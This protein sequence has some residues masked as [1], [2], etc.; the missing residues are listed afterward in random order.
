MDRS[1]EEAIRYISGEL[2]DNPNA[3]KS[4]LIDQAAQRFD[5]DPMQTEFLINKF[6][7]NT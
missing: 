3:N 5:L 7:M 1:M 6:I 2:K 4:Q